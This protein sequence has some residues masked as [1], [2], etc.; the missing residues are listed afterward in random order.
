MVNITFS[1]TF[2][3]GQRSVLWGVEAVIVCSVTSSAAITRRL[4]GGQ[5]GE[6][7]VSEG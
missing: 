5:V 6:L 7:S 1:R 2:L 4:E 3:F